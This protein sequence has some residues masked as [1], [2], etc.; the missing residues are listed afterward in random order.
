M[1]VEYSTTQN[2]L[3]YSATMHVLS[4]VII[5][6]CYGGTSAGTIVVEQTTNQRIEQNTNENATTPQIRKFHVISDIKYRY[7][8]TVVSSRVVNPTNFSQ[9]ITFAAVLPETAFV[10][11]FLIGSMLGHKIEQLKQAMSTI[12][13]DLHSGDLFSILNFNYVATNIH[14]ALTK[15]LEISKLEIQNISNTE[16][17]DIQEVGPSQKPEPIIIF[18]TDG[19]ANVGIRDSNTIV[20]SITE[21]NTCNASIFSLALGNDA[22]FNFLKLLSLRNSGFARKIYEA[23]DTALQL[24]D[25]YQQVSSPLIAHVQFQYPPEQ[26][27]NGT[28]NNMERLWAYLTIKQLLDKDKAMGDG[29]S[30]G[31]S[32]EK[33]RALELALRYSFVTPLTSLV[34]VKPNGTGQ[35]DTSQPDGSLQPTPIALNIQGR[36][37][38]TGTFRS[39]SSSTSC[40]G[41]TRDQP[42]LLR[43]SFG[44]SQISTPRLASFFGPQMRRMMVHEPRTTTA[45]VPAIL[46]LDDIIWLPL[47]SNSTTIALPTGSHYGTEYYQLATTNQTNVAYSNCTAPTN[48]PGHCRHLRHCHTFTKAEKSTN[49]LVTIERPNPQTAVVKFTPTAEEQRALAQEGIKCQLVVEYDVDRSQ[50]GELLMQDG[51]FVH[52]FAPQDLPPLRKHVTFVLDVSGSMTGTKIQQLQEAMGAILDELNQNDLFSIAVW[53]YNHTNAFYRE[54]LERLSGMRWGDYDED[55]EEVERQNRHVIASATRENITRA[56]QFI[57]MLSPVGES[58]VVQEATNQTQQTN[59][60]PQPILIFLTDGQANVGER[61]SNAIVNNVGRANTKNCSI[62]SLAFGEEPDFEFLKRLSLRNS[63]FARKIYEAS[64]TALQLRNFYRQVSSPLLSQ[65]VFKYQPEQNTLTKLKFRMLYSGS[66]HVVA[67]KLKQETFSSVVE[68][69]SSSGNSTYQYNPQTFSANTTNSTSFMERLWAYLTIQQLLDKMDA[70][71]TEEIE[72]T[73]SS[74]IEEP[75]DETQANQTVLDLALRTANLND[76]TWLAAVTNNNTVTLQTEANGTS[77]VLELAG[78]N[79]VNE[80]HGTCR[81]P[82]NHPGHCRHLRHCVLRAFTRSQQNFLPYFCRISNFVGVCCPDSLHSAVS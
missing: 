47:Y 48:E 5:L 6:L 33:Q 62:F 63:G 36:L 32:T 51:Y 64:D 56:K 68:G 37:G 29:N 3:G 42:P 54:R 31:N 15:A 77:E 22:D 71:A 45:P 80:A 30:N 38:G 23:S 65:V 25:F 46:G 13:D 53:D 75:F 12:L 24:G 7:A 76:I 66:E 21:T 17:N 28:W 81:T 49:N 69:K 2:S 72:I 27:N 43:F 82:G 55:D 18:L 44:S 74:S 61:N 40:S 50:S 60:K 78:E 35:V 59:Q 9:E 39:R 26:T 73:D 11:G 8:R 57:R 41:C 16:S 52:F 14:G 19:Q 34:V 58:N 79:Q 10:S 20:R 4:F 67:G 70:N 1:Y